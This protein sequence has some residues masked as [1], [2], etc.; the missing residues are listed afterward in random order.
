MKK[1]V[2]LV[3]LA[4]TIGC[5]S[6]EITTYQT[7]A[8]A[9]STID[10]AS[11]EYNHNDAQITQLCSGVTTPSAVYIP[12]TQQN[13]DILAKAQA[14]KDTAVNAMIAYESAKAAKGSTDT[15]TL[16]QNVNTAVAAL[17]ADIAEVVQLVKGG[18]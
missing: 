18:K 6:W 11:A 15:A 3:G 9:K 4:L 17:T 1:A 13:H 14:A 12:A 2:L 16:Q 5:S 8:S 10:C 7:L